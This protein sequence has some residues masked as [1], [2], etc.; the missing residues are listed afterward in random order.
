MNDKEN[1]YLESKSKVK[2]TSPK[3]TY[4]QQTDQDLTPRFLLSTIRHELRTPLN[5]IIGYSEMLL[6]DAQELGKENLVSDL[7]KIQTAGQVIHEVINDFFETSEPSAKLENLKDEKMGNKLQYDLRIPLNTVIGYCEMLQEEYDSNIIANFGRDLKK[8]LA[9]AEIFLTHISAILANTPVETG[10]TDSILETSYGLSATEEGE[11]AIYPISDDRSSL[12]TDHERSVLVVDDNSTNR[13]LLS[14]YLKRQG[15]G[16]ITA[17]NG[18]QAL[19]MVNSKPFDLVLLDVLMPGINGYQVLKRLKSEKAWRD[20][21]VIMISALKDMEG[22]VKCIE[23]GADDYLPKPFNPVVLKA[24]INNCLER[25]RL[26]DLEKEHKKMIKETFGKY[27][28]HEVRDEVLSGRIPLDGEKKDVTV[29]FADLR[30]FTPLTDSMPPK[31]MVRILNGYFSE[32]APAIRSHHGSILQYLGDEIYAVFGAPIPLSD[33]PRQAVAAALDMRKRLID[34]NKLL[35]K[36][37][38]VMLRHGI[39]IHSGPAVAANLGSSERLTYGLV[40][41]TVNLASRIQG[42]TKQFNTDILVSAQ[43]RARLGDEFAVVELPA[44]FVKGKNS[45]AEIYK[46]L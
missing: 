1:H 39:G 17:E 44:T 45:P 18:I 36:Q 6:E 16:V 24:R 13:D 27:V 8:I 42:L 26:S 23:L 29:L 2:P 33:H 3:Q 35:E 34:V 31:E 38:H 9:A 14:R 5:A 46:V 4:H 37:G 28:S 20:I 30:D 40:G 22:V 11:N 15:L 12:I 19:E 21:P 10:N 32:M 43:S 25:K 41:D 7:Q